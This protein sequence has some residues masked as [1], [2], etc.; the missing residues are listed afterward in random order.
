MVHV[1]S[2][3]HIVYV[4]QSINNEKTS[5]HACDRILLCV[6]LDDFNRKIKTII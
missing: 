4:A 2:H 5:F 3:R 1:L 6:V